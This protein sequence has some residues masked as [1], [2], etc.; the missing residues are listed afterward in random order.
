MGASPVAAN[1]P[2]LLAGRGGSEVERPLRAAPEAMKA[3]RGVPIYE[4]GR[5]RRNKALTFQPRTGL[6]VS[7]SQ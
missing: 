1:D 4:N 3:G 2:A 7:W 5:L 6:I